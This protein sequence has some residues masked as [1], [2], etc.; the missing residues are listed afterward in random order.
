[1][2]L[3]KSHAIEFAFVLVLWFLRQCQTGKVLNLNK[4]IFAL[5]IKESTMYKTVGIFHKVTC[6][7]RKHFILKWN[8]A[9][10]LR[11]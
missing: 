9:R 4:K 5:H 3:N 1:M 11:F 6:S 8:Y 7:G 10:E 2:K